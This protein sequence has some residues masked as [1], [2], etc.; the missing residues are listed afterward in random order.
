MK[1]LKINLGSPVPIYEQVAEE[2]KRMI[3]AGEL[4]EGESLPTIRS[5]AKQLEVDKNTIARAYQQL[6]IE[7][8]IAGNRRKGSY[9]KKP[10]YEVP[11]SGTKIFKDQIIKLIQNGL[12]KDEIEKIFYDNLNQIFD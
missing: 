3:K 8:I 6:Y 5:L 12:N 7:D 1:M 9:V 2:I 10:V 11:V 4:K